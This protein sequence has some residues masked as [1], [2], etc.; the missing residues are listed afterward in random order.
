MLDCIIVLLD[1]VATL[2]DGISQQKVEHNLH[3]LQ[4]TKVE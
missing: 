3:F 1:N 2:I 4:I